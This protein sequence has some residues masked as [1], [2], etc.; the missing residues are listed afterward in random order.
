MR[1]QKEIWWVDKALCGTLMHV[2]TNWVDA[3]L[4]VAMKITQWLAY[5][6]P[7]CILNQVPQEISSENDLNSSR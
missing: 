5:F 4:F 2:T 6:T 3:S 7:Q 1:W